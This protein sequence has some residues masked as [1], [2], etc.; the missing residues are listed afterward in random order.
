MNRSLIPAAAALAFT[1]LL[2]QITDRTTGQP[3]RNV[4][5]QVTQGHTMLR[6]RTDENGRFELK[7]VKPGSHSLRYLS[8][9]V[10]PQTVSITVKGAKQRISITACS[11]TLDYSCA[12]GG[13][14]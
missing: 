1:V 5:V 10:P 2:G 8:D 3:L 4:A 6:A 7:G 9:D 13:G 11:T 12:G 14:S